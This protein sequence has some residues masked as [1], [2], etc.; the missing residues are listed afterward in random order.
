M[1]PTKDGA[2]LQRDAGA[3][4]KIVFVAGVIHRP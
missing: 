2:A 3:A 1:R 4:L